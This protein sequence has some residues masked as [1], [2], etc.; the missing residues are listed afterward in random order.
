MRSWRCTKPAPRT[1]SSRGHCRGRRSRC[2]GG[3]ANKQLHSDYRSSRPD[4]PGY[5]E[6]QRAEVDRLHALLLELSAA[7][8]THPFWE[9][10][11]RDKVVEARMALK[12]AHET[13]DD[14]EAA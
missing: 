10:V 9:T 14:T 3:R 12:H 8:A 5:T 1:R 2:P 4:S 11:E 6:E 7:V 13:S